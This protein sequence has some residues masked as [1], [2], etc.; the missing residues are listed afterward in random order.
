MLRSLAQ[1]HSFDEIVAMFDHRLSMNAR[2][3]LLS[4]TK[5]S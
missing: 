5:Q 2:M 4:L 1:E 3:Y